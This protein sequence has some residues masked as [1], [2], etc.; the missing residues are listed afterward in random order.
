MQTIFAPG[1]EEIQLANVCGPSHVLC[2][3]RPSGAL[4]T[5]P[6]LDSFGRGVHLRYVPEQGRT[7]GEFERKTF[8][9]GTPAITSI[10][11]TELRMGPG[12]HRLPGP[13]FLY[14]TGGDGDG[15][16]VSFLISRV[17]VHEPHYHWLPALLTENT[18]YV[19]PD[20]H[21]W[22]SAAANVAGA[23]IVH[24]GLFS[25]TV[26]AE[27]LPIGGGTLMLTRALQTIYT[28]F[29]L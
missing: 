15:W 17:P 8:A 14:L 27:P 28:G 22:L 6:R 2:V 13:G 25:L 11:K 24:N 23:P 16:S 29:Y 12:S 9:K 5:S 10:V 7:E 19:V 4:G 20:G 18:L 26:T 21:D 3:A 1:N